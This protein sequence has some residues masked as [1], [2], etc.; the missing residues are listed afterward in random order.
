MAVIL[1]PEVNKAAQKSLLK[2]LRIEVVYLYHRIYK[3]A[4]FVCMALKSINGI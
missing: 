1:D 2:I 3:I 4:S